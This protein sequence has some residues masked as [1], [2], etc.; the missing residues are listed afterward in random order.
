MYSSYRK[1]GVM[2]AAAPMVPMGGCGHCSSPPAS[3]QAG[4]LQ[5]SCAVGHHAGAEL[6]T[7][8]AEAIKELHTIRRSEVR[9]LL[10]PASRA[11]GEACLA[12]D[13][14]GVACADG[15]NS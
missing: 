13:A 11:S 6:R 1:L 10:T 2:D 4:M 15:R 9:R 5:L 7:D 8:H 12:T 14:I 3:E